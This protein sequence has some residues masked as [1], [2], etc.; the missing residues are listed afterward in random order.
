MARTRSAVKVVEEPEREDTGMVLPP[1][2]SQDD[3]SQDPAVWDM[4][5]VGAGV[6]GAAFAYQQGCSGRRVLLLE[7]DLSQP[8]RIVGEL[9]QPGG[10][11][12]LKR[13]GLAHCCEGIGAQKVKGY[14]MFKEGRE[15]KVDY[16]TEGLGDDIAGRSFHHGRFVQKL[17]QSAA[18]QKSVTVR[19]G[20]VRRLIND[21][22]SEWEEGQ[23]V[24]GVC[25]KG[26]DGQDHVAKAHLTIVCDGMYSAFRKKMARTDVKHPS[27]FIGLLLKDCPLPHQGYGHVILGKPSPFLFYP[28][29]KTEVRCLVDYPGEKL[30]SVTSGELEWYLLDT[31]APQVPAC[32]RTHFETA[33]KHGRIR[34][35][36]NKQVTSQ[37]LHP[38]GALLLGDA[39]N[40][41]HPLTGGGMTVAFSDTNLLCDMLRPLPTFANKVTVSDATSAFYVRRKPLSATINTLANALYK[42]FCASD[43]KAHEE[44]RQACFD[45][46]ALGGVYSAG[47]VS[48]LS[49]LNPRPSVLVMHFFMVALFGVGR[50]LFPRPTLRGVWLGMLLLY[51]AACIILPIIWKEGVRAVF[52][53]WLAPK[54]RLSGMQR[55]IAE[56]L[57]T[58]ANAARKMLTATGARLAHTSLRST[59]FLRT[60]GGRRLRMSQQINEALG[61]L[62]LMITNAAA[63]AGAGAAAPAAQQQLSTAA[64]SAAGRKGSIKQ[65]LES[66]FQEGIDAAFPALAG[67]VPAIV[68]PCNNPKFGDYQCNNAMALHGRLKGQPDAP[69][70]PRAVAEAILAALP[71][72]GMVAE[73]SL[74]G[75]GFI[76]IKLDSNWLAQH[77]T[78]MLR[79]G[80]AT[81]AP[82]G[83]AGQKVVVDFSSPNVAKEMHVGHLRSTIL[84]DTIARTLEFCGA[85]V[86]RLNH[87]GD[88]GTQFGMLIQYMAEKRE[89]GL[90]AATDED[91]ADLQVLYRAAKQRFD[92]EEDFK[93][94]AREAVTELQSGR[95]EYLQAWQRICD[96][97][98]RE[99]QKIYDRLDVTLEERGESFY[100][101]MLKPLVEDL[102][103]RGVAVE[104]DGA[105]CVFVE[106]K[107]IPLIV[108]KSDGGFG[109]ASTDMAAVKHRVEQ[110]KAA[111][112]VWP[113][114]LI[115]DAL[116][117][118]FPATFEHRVEQEKAG[119]VKHRVEQEKADWIIY[120][121]DMGQAMHF[122]LVFA[123]A[124]KAGYLPTDR[125]VRIDHVGFGLVLGDDGKKFRSRSGDVVRLVEL[126]DEAKRRIVDT[127]KERRPDAT[128]EE[129]EEASRA[130]GYGAVK[131]ADLK[132]HRTTNYRF[133]Y[134]DM[135]S[136]QGNT[137]VYQLYAHARIASIV[138]KSGRD[139]A[140]LCQ[141]AEVKLGH[142]KEV[143]LALVISRF[144]DAVDAMLEELLPH[145]LTEY[146]YDL[147]TVFNQFYTECQV[148]GSPEEESRLLLCEATALTMRACFQLLGIHQRGWVRDAQQQVVIAAGPERSGSTFLYNALRLLFQ[149]ARQPCDAYYLKCIT[150]AALDERGVGQPGA[151]HVLVKTHGWSEHWDLSRATHIFV[152]H[153]DLAQVLA[154]Y[155]RLGWAWEVPEEYVRHHVIWQRHAELDVAFEDIAA[156]PLWALQQLADRLGLQVDCAAV[157]HDLDI[158]PVPK[159][160][161][162]PVTQLWPAHI[163]PA[164]WEQRAAAEAAA[165]AAAAGE[166]EQ[167]AQAAAATGLPSRDSNSSHPRAASGGGKLSAAEAERLWQQFPDFYHLYPRYSQRS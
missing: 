18:S 95:P 57:A 136:Q 147:A 87:I 160:W 100:N 45:Y 164:F 123:G 104:S 127:V 154:S 64:G 133:S 156:R 119:Q 39:F 23:V 85:D 36:Q 27:F 30:P 41:R 11:L 48:L 115:T 150:D 65:R 4:I 62:D 55:Q 121:T 86:K 91:V 132:N 33:V 148:V 67:Q 101:P 167:P 7:R 9:L 40:M 138:R 135:L 73:T 158:L 1:V 43:S 96:A 122:E 162:D 105:K 161:M 51:S 46:L 151:P 134:D 129:I 47:P 152:T 140:A 13:L 141:T 68:Q 113:A 8:D 26:T 106:G 107:E 28:I 10:Y 77:V 52:L 159:H 29:S 142:E 32:L 98:R 92:E 126:L 14:C 15:A 146:L 155:H 102:L 61:K 6:A 125:K 137:A 163:S 35:M 108:Q 117:P 79:N 56:E 116:P 58:Q 157:L 143:A 5:I 76:N 114:A 78:H 16:P 145:R 17:R 130:M 2:P 34:C 31:V 74:A 81:W 25:Y 128:P 71:E 53:P 153:R 42:V 124:E 111:V 22:D 3:E 72:T 63:G 80:I 54:P 165:A 21:M 59:R 120:I 44:M 49:G 83:Y 131:Y 139:I 99:F 88:W 12:L 166:Q 20:Y 97:S 118:A 38:A 110:E 37:P 112:A 70:N 69:K 24:T 82:L 19:Q 109:Y 149:H 84:G 94:R 66:A 89:G 50:L 75:P 90:N 93:T 103:A 60:Q 144:S